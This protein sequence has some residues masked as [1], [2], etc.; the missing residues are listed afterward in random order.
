MGKADLRH[1][2]SCQFKTLIRADVPM[3][4]CPEHGSQTVAAGNVSVHSG[5]TASFRQTI[6]PITLQRDE[7][8]FAFV[9]SDRDGMNFLRYW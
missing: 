6:P 2:E 5:T 1:L 8:P 7:V 4:K 9:R 3:V